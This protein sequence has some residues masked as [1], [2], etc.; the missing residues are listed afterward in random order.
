MTDAGFIVNL[1]HDID[2]V[3][4]TYQ[5]FT[6][7]LAKF[8]I[9]NLFDF[10]SRQDPFWTFETIMEIEANANCRSTF[11]FL[12]E[13]L[14][15]RPLPVKNWNLTLGKY[16]FSSPRIREIIKKLDRGGWEIALHG[17]YNSY[18]NKELLSEEKNKLEAVLGKEVQGIRQ[19]FLNL[20]IPL[21]WQIH[22]ELGF[23]YDS[24]LGRRHE[25][26][27]I[28]DHYT[29]FRNP[30]TGMVIIPLTLMD[31][32][33][34]YKLNGDLYGAWK[35]ILKVINEAEENK[36][37]LTVLWH[38][39]FFNEREHPGFS[40]LYKK[41]IWECK[42]RGAKFYTSHEIYELFSSIESSTAV[43]GGGAKSN[44]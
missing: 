28:D 16:R 13:S 8:R 4:K 29:P 11:F 39:N 7:D 22:K 38:N 12:E 34:A 40:N 23:K 1:T 19:H 44:K 43:A 17:S 5:Y 10:F 41:L 18:K 2:F 14:P 33:L 25:V 36:A 37:V 21:T 20:E 26:G 30:E 6:H 24:S 9:T 31:T 32:Y 42:N 27:F 15:W 3:K 35:R